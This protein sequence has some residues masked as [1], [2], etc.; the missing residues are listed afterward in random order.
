MSKKPL[1]SEG[2]EREEWEYP[3][4]AAAV[5]RDEEDIRHSFTEE[6]W[7]EHY[8][9]K[10]PQNLSKWGDR[11][12]SQLNA[13]YRKGIT[14]IRESLPKVGLSATETRTYRDTTTGRFVDKAFA[15]AHPLSVKATSVNVFQN[16]R[17]GQI[18]SF[19]DVALKIRGLPQ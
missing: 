4:W 9:S 14:D 16:I 10:Y 1:R 5:L 19:Q 18:I 12:E 7:K 6:A 15:E 8:R 2:R 17:T 11:S 13:L 3:V